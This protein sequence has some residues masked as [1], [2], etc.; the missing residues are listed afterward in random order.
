MDF[1]KENHY[2]ILGKFCSKRI[3]DQFIEKLQLK[4]H[5]KVKMNKKMNRTNMSFMV[6]LLKMN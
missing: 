2:N 4:Q 1:I 5:F 6:S 3:E